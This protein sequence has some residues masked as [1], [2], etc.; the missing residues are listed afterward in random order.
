[1]YAKLTDKV[2]VT[3]EDDRLWVTETAYAMK[4]T[5]EDIGITGGTPEEL[6]PM[7][8]PYLVFQNQLEFEVLW[9]D[10]LFMHVPGV[11]E[12]RG[13]LELENG[14]W[15]DTVD[16]KEYE[17][18]INGDGS[19][20]GMNIF[21]STFL[22][23]GASAAWIIDKAIGNEGLEAAAETF[24]ELWDN[25]SLDLEKTE[26]DLNRLGYTYLG[27]NEMQKALMV[28]NLNTE[29]F[30]DSWNVY[31]SYGEA[32]MVNGDTSAAIN[33]YRRSLELNP[34]NDN[35]RKMLER[36]VITENE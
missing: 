16:K 26:A 2:Y 5:D 34:E 31:D 11:E 1:M 12:A 33:N 3:F 23:R 32:L 7:I 20:S 14:H 8:G 30:P 9:D 25:R 15:Q 13:L 24:R 6:Q 18:S 4:K 36:L 35:G 19:V 10:G 21:A 22:V 29:T 27:K 17:F 28:F